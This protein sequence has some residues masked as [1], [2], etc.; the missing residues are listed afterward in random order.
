[1]IFNIAEKVKWKSVRPNL[2]SRFPTNAFAGDGED[3]PDF[4]MKM[5]MSS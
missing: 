3:P 4:S 5:K 1:M 2:R